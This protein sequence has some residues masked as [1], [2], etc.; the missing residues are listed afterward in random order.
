MREELE[1]VL[2]TGT[3]ALEDVWETATAGGLEDDA[4]EEA[5]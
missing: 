4:A 1:P 5:S 3:G 2:F